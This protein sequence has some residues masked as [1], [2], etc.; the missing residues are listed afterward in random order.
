MEENISL[1][2]GEGG[3]LNEVFTS[4]SSVSLVFVVPSSL[5]PM[6]RRKDTTL[7]APRL[8]ALLFASDSKCGQNLLLAPL[9]FKVR[10][11]LKRAYT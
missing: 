7:N 5:L 1:W 8:L 2:E 10:W 11:L 9:Q 4:W 6:V 3:S